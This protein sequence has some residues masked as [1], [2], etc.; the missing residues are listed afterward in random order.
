VLS[1]INKGATF[2]DSPGS[3]IRRTVT[4]AAEYAVDEE[5]YI[6]NSI[7]KYSSVPAFFQTWE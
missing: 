3:R 4:H 5:A 1:F 6:P 7:P 2:L